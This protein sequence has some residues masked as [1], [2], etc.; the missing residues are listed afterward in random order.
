MTAKRNG[1]GR[2]APNPTNGKHPIQKLS[3]FRPQRQNLNLHKPHGL[4]ALDKSI[5]RDGLIGGITVAADGESF[6]GS[7]RL[8]TLADIMPDV[9]VKVV[10]TAGD[11]LIV[12]RRTDIQN[13][14]DP[15]ARRLSYAA[16]AV[17]VMDWNPDGELLA[18]LAAEDAVIA[19]LARQE[20]ASLKAL[21]ELHRPS[22]DWTADDDFKFERMDEL[23]RKWKTCVGFRRP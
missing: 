3:A 10:D 6:D 16:N 1:S 13:A 2:A 18:A 21:A 11:T 8:E 7:A 17:Q 9:K 14:D 5:R 15:R 4:A 22:A 23:K 12:N 19:D 20:N